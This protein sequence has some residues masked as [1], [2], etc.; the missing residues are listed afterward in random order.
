MLTLLFSISYLSYHIVEKLISSLGVNT[1][2]SGSDQIGPNCC[3]QYD[4]SAGRSDSF[5]QSW[6]LGSCKRPGLR[7]SS[8]LT[9]D[10]RTASRAEREPPHQ[11]GILFHFATSN[12]VHDIHSA[13]EALAMHTSKYNGTYKYLGR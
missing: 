3:I 9:E 6:N 5:L 7:W 2:N 11:P 12:I 13:I 1:S 8:S 4:C 10:S